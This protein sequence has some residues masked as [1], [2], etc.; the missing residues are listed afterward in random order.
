[1][2]SE[3][4]RE[5]NV[6]LPKTV[7]V[8]KSRSIAICMGCDPLLIKTREATYRA[9]AC[10]CVCVTVCACVGLLTSRFACVYVLVDA[11]RCYCISY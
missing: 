3:R 8:G 4:S 11:S 6:C 1:M 10:V 7:L 5:T 9:C 2:N